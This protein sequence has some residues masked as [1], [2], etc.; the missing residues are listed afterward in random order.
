MFLR[1]FWFNFAA[2]KP[3]S[4]IFVRS[5]NTP[6]MNTSLEHKTLAQTQRAQHHESQS[7]K[8]FPSRTI[9]HAKLEMTEPN[10]HDEQE[11]DAV[12]NT[13]MSGGKIARK[14][15]S[16]GS[17]SSGIAVSPQMESQLSQ[18]Q[19]GGRPMPQGLKSMMESGFGL[20]FSQVR[21][22]TDNEAARM[23]S[24]IHAKAFTH[25]NDIYFNRGQF[26]P[27]TT[28]GQRLVAHELAHT[29]QNNGVIARKKKKETPEERA[30][31]KKDERLKKEKEI[32]HGLY[33][34]LKDDSFQSRV[35]IIS[36]NQTDGLII[37]DNIL[38]DCESLI[39]QIGK[40]VG[41]EQ[42]VQQV[43]NTLTQV[44][45][46]MDILVNA[47]L[48][49]P[50]KDAAGNLSMT[51]WIETRDHFV[52]VVRSLANKAHNPA[53]AVLMYEG[54]YY[55]SDYNPVLN[56]ATENAAKEGLSSGLSKYGAVCN[57]AVYGSLIASDAVYQF[58]PKEAHNKSQRSNKGRIS[59][60][61]S[62]DRYNW[63]DY[64]LQGSGYGEKALDNAKQG[65]VV[66]FWN[67]SAEW[68]KDSLLDSFDEWLTEKSIEKEPK[69][70]RTKKD[71]RD[72]LI[73]L[74]NDNKFTVLDDLIK[75][76][77]VNAS[78]IEIIAG[79]QGSGSSK[80]FLLSGAHDS[81][82]TNGIARN[83][84]GDLDWKSANSIRNGRMMRLFPIQ[85]SDDFVSVD[86]SDM[87]YE[88]QTYKNVATGEYEVPDLAPVDKKTPLT[89]R[90]VFKNSLNEVTI[91]WISKEN[92]IGE[93]ESFDQDASSEQNP[94]L[95]KAIP[96]DEKV[97]TE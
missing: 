30:Q 4:G 63:S 32:R 67:L 50:E 47:K 91:N 90:S 23:S 17:N 51:D 34:D 48:I 11:A 68:I 62:G 54:T 61:S 95:D 58:N 87:Q 8:A 97:Q 33:N 12:A 72:Q 35:V 82:K 53:I 60:L 74:A 81:K 19:G 84:N 27:D 88:Q 73:K 94:Q 10:D 92:I 56:G 43:Y 77:N 36:N 39:N 31:R 86:I 78:H 96:E 13:I 66:I 44:S 14:I 59:G 3:T 85:R 20:D 46:A 69:E 37:I 40:K 70:E 75:T 65:D 64:N 25:G 9:V 52:N 89:M 22:H 29:I 57:N 45:S 15:S 28:E 24:S 83:G 79:V 18:L 5:M 16:G 93:V 26:A 76:K 7:A 49:N 21:L 1:F 55:R 42:V 38:D 6:S 71:R 80:K 41:K 2:C